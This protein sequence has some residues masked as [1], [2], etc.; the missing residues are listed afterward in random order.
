MWY[1]VLVERPGQRR[2]VTL[3]SLVSQS[4]VGAGR[5]GDASAQALLSQQKPLVRHN[6]RSEFNAPDAV[7]CLPGTF[8]TAACMT[9]ASDES[10]T[11]RI[12][13]GLSHGFSCT[14]TYRTGSRAVCSMTFLFCIRTAQLRCPDNGPLA[15][16]GVTVAVVVFTITIIYM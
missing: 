7:N 3:M 1:T 11:T 9:P 8:A 2:A 6:P 15:V 10:F 5:L 12:S 16:A 14:S 13:H 4:P